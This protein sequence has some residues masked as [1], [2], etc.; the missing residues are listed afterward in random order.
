MI[1]IIDKGY[2]LTKHIGL[3]ISSSL[4]YKNTEEIIQNCNDYKVITFNEYQI[5]HLHRKYFVLGMTSGTMI[6]LKTIKIRHGFS[7][8]AFYSLLFCRESLNP[9]CG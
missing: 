4:I 9:F 3:V 8:F 7:L 1:D 5:T 6:L 2:N